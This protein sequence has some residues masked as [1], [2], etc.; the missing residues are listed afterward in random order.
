M[1]LDLTSCSRTTRSIWSQHTHYDVDSD[2]EKHE[3]R[4]LCFVVTWTIHELR[5]RS[6]WQTFSSPWPRSMNTHVFLSLA[7][8]EHTLP[9]SSISCFIECHV[10][11][12]QCDVVL[13]IESMMQQSRRGGT[14]SQAVCL[15][16]GTSPQSMHGLIDVLS[17]WSI[18]KML[19]MSCS[20]YDTAF[21]NSTFYQSV[22]PPV[23]WRHD[24]DTNVLR[25]FWRRNTWTIVSARAS[26]LLGLK[27]C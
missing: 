13:Q 19:W 25:L 7:Y 5:L 23:L 14:T 20:N 6:Y 10:R 24:C 3:L 2:D 15:V 12:S 9:R 21:S 17:K 16:D 4:F 18:E 1:C 26:A 22:A 27:T 11:I 8:G